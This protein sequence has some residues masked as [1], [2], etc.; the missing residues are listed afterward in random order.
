[1]IY[2]SDDENNICMWKVE[3]EKSR[4]ENYLCKKNQNIIGFI[5]YFTAK[6]ITFSF[7]EY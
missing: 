4:L 7:F 6:Y 2:E 5:S 1:M 3:R